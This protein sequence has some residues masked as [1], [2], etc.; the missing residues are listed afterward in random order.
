MEY[1]GLLE[2]TLIPGSREIPWFCPDNPGIPGLVKR[3][4]I[5]IS[6]LHCLL[7][8]IDIS[9]YAGAG[10]WANSRS[11]ASG[12]HSGSRQGRRK[13]VQVGGGGGAGAG[14]HGMQLPQLIEYEK[15]IEYL[16]SGAPPLPDEH[17][18]HTRSYP[19]V[20]FVRGNFSPVPPEKLLGFRLLLWN[21]AKTKQ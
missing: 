6:I 9:N 13:C 21:L 1:F 4:G 15:L 12:W 3:S 17:Y 2:K 19:A 7:E 5:D 11:G 16:S 8:R 20:P 18:V 10:R 14:F